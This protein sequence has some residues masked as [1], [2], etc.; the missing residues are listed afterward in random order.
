MVGHNEAFQAS[1][2]GV[3]TVPGDQERCR[4]DVAQLQAVDGRQGAK[5][6]VLDGEQV[7]ITDGRWLVALGTDLGSATFRV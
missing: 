6:G 7:A 2:I 4:V 3:W 1:Q 5:L